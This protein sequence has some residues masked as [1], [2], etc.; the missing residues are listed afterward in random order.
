M[1]ALKQPC[2]QLLLDHVSEFGPEGSAF[3]DAAF[4]NKRLIPGFGPR[5]GE[6][7]WQKRLT[8]TSEG[9][10][11][12]LRYVHQA[13]ARKVP[14]IRSKFDK[15]ALEEAVLMSQLLVSSIAELKDQHPIKEEDVQTV[16]QT[17]LDGDINFELELPSA[18]SEKKKQFQPTDLSK[19]KNLLATTLAD[20]DGKLSSVGKGPTI[21]AGQLEKQAFE[22]CMN[23]L[24]HDL[25][26][27]KVWR[28]KCLD[29]DAAI[30]FQKLQ[31][32]TLRHN[33]AREIADSVFD[34]EKGPS[35]FAQFNTWS[36]RDANNLQTVDAAMQHIARL[37][38]LD[39]TT[40]VHC[41]CLLNWAAPATY[42]GETRHGKQT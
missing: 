7:P 36:S 25:D 11:L 38:Q 17:F 40:Q 34:E 14:Q 31:H 5:T 42:K 12:F 3:T 8:I 35:W 13:H 19:L 20:R 4:A 29:R 27:Y 10:E 39:K 32:A 23:S 18:R 16:I 33:R 22:L 26:Q 6:K 24:N 30:H 15:S 21:T 28:T 1:L 41:L 37:H 9:F 2:I